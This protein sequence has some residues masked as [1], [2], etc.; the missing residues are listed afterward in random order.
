MANITLEFSIN[1][2]LLPIIDAMRHDMT[3]EEIFRKALEFG[4]LD[5]MDNQVRYHREHLTHRLAGQLD[6]FR[7]GEPVLTVAAPVAP[8]PAAVSPINELT[9]RRA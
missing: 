8:K 9:Q 4:L 5:L 2:N 1:D 6:E 3:R 7:Q